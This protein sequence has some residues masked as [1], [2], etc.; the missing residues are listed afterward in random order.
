M[1]SDPK[2]ITSAITPLKTKN[3]IVNSTWSAAVPTWIRQERAYTSWYSCPI[4]SP[5]IRKPITTV[6]E[7]ARRLSDVVPN[8]SWTR[9]A[10][11]PSRFMCEI[12]RSA[13]VFSFPVAWL[14]TATMTSAAG[15]TDS[16]T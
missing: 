15:S 9:L 13:N 12:R 7:A 5:Q 11:G 6:N 4:E 1:S 8:R 10:V 2:T 16:A 3:Q 14:K